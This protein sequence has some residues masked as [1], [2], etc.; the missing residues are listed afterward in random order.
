MTKK[1]SEG[2]KGESTADYP[3]R[4]VRCYVC[5]GTG[6]IPLFTGIETGRLICP[7]CFGTGHIINHISISYD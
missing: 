1:E 5:E 7:S 4:V 3:T 2:Y 6:Q